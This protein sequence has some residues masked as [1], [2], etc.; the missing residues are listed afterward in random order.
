MALKNRDGKNITSIPATPFCDVV[1]EQM[2][3]IEEYGF[4]F[5]G[6]TR[7]YGGKTAMLFFL[8]E[9]QILVGKG[10]VVAAGSTNYIPYRKSELENEIPEEKIIQFGVSYAMRKQRDKVIKR[11]SEADILQRGKIKENPLIGRIPTR[12]EIM[13][14]LDELLMSM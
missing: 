9:P 13:Y 3:W 8:D 6:V 14:E 4:R 5:R 2:D 12:Q 1:Y 11:I 10:S 7:K